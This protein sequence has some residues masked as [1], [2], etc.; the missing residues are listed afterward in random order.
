MCMGYDYKRNLPISDS[1]RVQVGSR[2]KVCDY[3]RKAAGILVTEI[4]T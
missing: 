3:L 4:N 2:G 1:F